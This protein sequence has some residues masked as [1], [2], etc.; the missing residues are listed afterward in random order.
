MDGMS[1]SAW[2]KPAEDVVFDALFDD[3]TGV[4]GAAFRDR[5]ASAAFSVVA[6][7]VAST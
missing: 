5:T 7:S 6:A 3:D 4:A 1:G 2:D